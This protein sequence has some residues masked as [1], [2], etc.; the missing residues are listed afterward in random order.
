MFEKSD[1]CKL[2]LEY[3]CPWQYK[4]IGMDKEMLKLSIETVF[5]DCLCEITYS[6]SS[7]T[8]KY[9]SYRI[10]LQ[11]NSEEERVGFFQALK[12]NAQI[13]MVI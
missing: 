4:A 9:H 12:S 3:P 5:K 2:E 11:V 8:G 1:G 7:K 10:D 13:K 6:N